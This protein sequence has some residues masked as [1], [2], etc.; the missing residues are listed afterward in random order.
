MFH[1]CGH[2][3]AQQAH[4]SRRCFTRMKTTPSTNRLDL[5]RSFFF[6]LSFC[7]C[8]K[9]FSKSHYSDFVFIINVTFQ[10]YYSQIYTHSRV[11]H[12][13]WRLHYLWNLPLRLSPDLLDRLQQNSLRSRSQFNK[14]KLP[15]SLQVIANYKSIRFAWQHHAQV[16]LISTWR[17]TLSLPN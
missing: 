5:S 6:S 12:H 1:C 17:N 16:A 9:P 15:F 4:P 8:L 14:S 7:M 10:D 3:R 2:R 13:S 11:P